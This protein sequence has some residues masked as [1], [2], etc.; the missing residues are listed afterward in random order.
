MW[1][2]DYLYSFGLFQSFTDL[3][4]CEPLIDLKQTGYSDSDE[5]DV[6]LSIYSFCICGSVLSHD[7]ES[8]LVCKKK[9]KVECVVCRTGCRP[10]DLISMCVKCGHGGHLDHLQS[11]FSSEIV[12]ASGLFEFLFF[13]G[14]GCLCLSNE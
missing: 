12:C 7:Y 4:K 1:Y 5:L 6:N 11:W 3:M 2:A 10:F 9:K 8:C 13:S 14:C